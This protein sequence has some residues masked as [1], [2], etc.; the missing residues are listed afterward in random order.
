VVDSIT[1]VDSRAA[2]AEAREIGQ[3]NETRCGRDRDG[4]PLVARSPVHVSKDFGSI[5]AIQA[6]RYF[7]QPLVSW[8]FQ[9]AAGMNRSASGPP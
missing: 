1:V 8:D 5:A 7:A 9:E 3:I 4:R 6:D 2:L